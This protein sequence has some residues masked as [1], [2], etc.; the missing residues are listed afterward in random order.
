M[1]EVI[2]FQDIQGLSNNYPLDDSIVVS[3]LNFASAL[4]PRYNFD[5]NMMLLLLSNRAFQKND[6]TAGLAF[7]RRFNLNNADRARGRYENTQRTRFRNHMLQ[8]AKHLA[9]IGNVKESVRIV[10]RFETA[11]MKLVCYA[12]MANSIYSKDYNS[13]AFVFLD[14][15]YS[16]MESM[17]NPAVPD[18]LEYRSRLVRVLQHI[19]GER[20]I[21]MSDEIV[22]STSEQ[23]RLLSAVGVVRG[24]CERGDYYNAVKSIPPTLTEG[25]ELFCKTFI[26]LYSVRADE[27]V[28]NK[29]PWAAMDKFV[30][31]GDYIQ[32]TGFLF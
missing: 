32:F 23:R 10:E 21:E 24:T 25:Q 31:F 6:T 2:L 13:N 11:A 30:S 18:F 8:V 5:A 26:L 4:P 12:D 20:M 9:S 3:A 28:N 14:S 17:P 7:Y 19:G 29:S 22:R 16:K 1:D 27:Q 15:A